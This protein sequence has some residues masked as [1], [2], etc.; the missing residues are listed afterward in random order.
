MTHWVTLSDLPRDDQ[1][2]VVAVL[3]D[4]CEQSGDPRPL[5]R[6][7][8][9]GDVLGGRE[10]ASVPPAVRN[11]IAAVLTRRIPPDPCGDAPDCPHPL[12][13]NDG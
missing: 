2:Q 3:A 5:G 7:L 9:G 4:W 10:P 8:A 11:R 1:E 6:A 12:C 13:R